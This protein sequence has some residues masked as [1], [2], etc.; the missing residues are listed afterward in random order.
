MTLR[1][2]SAPVDELVSRASAIDRPQDDCARV[3]SRLDGKLAAHFGKHELALRRCLTRPESK[4]AEKKA[5]AAEK[6]PGPVPRRKG[7]DWMKDFDLK[8]SPPLWLAAQASGIRRD[9]A[10]ADALS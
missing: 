4:D 1:W 3:E 9:Q 5:A 6:A 7:S 8:K 2:D 10:Q